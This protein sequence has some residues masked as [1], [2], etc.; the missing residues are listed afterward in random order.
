MSYERINPPWPATVGAGNPGKSVTENSCVGA[1]SASAAETQ[2]DPMTSATSWATFP[3][4]F[5][6]ASAALSAAPIGS[7]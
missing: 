1:P 5:L 6:S 4:I 3:V 7:E 2:P